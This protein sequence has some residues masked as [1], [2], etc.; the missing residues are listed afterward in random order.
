MTRDG[1]GRTPNPRDARLEFFATRALESGRLLPDIP[2]GE[3]YR[4][5]AGIQWRPKDYVELSAGYQF[6]WFGGL[7]FDDVALPPSGA[8]VLDGEYDPDWAHQA[9]VSLRVRF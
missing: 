9:G 4:F 3:Q 5:A 6:L 8:V 7:E 2:A 1:T